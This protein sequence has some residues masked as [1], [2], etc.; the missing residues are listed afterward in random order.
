MARIVAAMA[1]THSPGLTGWFTRA[2]EAYQQ[3]ALGATAEMRRRLEAA[4]PDALVMFTNDHLLNWPINNI[5]EY[6][7]GIGE[8]HV[9]PADWFDEW[10]GM[11]K[12]RVPGHP[13]L[14][15]WIVNEGARRRL[16]FAWLRR[17]QFDDGISVPTHYL[18]PDA[19][20]RLVP[21]GMNCTVPPIPTPERAYHV[22]SVLR[23]VLHAY[24]GDD[25]IAV[26]ATG[27]LSHE[28]GGPRYFWVDEEFDRWFL[29]LLAKG[30]H[31]TLLA[32]CTLARMEGAGPGGPVEVRPRAS[33]GWTAIRPGRGLLPEAEFAKPFLQIWDL[34][35]GTH[36]RMGHGIAVP[37]EPFPGVMGTA[38]DE[39]G[40]HS[41]MPPRKNGGNMD[42]KHLVAGAT[43]YLPV[44]VDGA[45]FSVGDAHAAQGDGEVCVT[46][47]EMV[48]RVT[49]RF[50][51]QPSRVLKEPQLRTRGPLA[52]GTNHG[53][54][55]ATT[56]DAPDRCAAAQ[57]AVRYM[58]DHLVTERG[59]S[60]EEAY[61]LSSVAVDLKI[62]EIVDT[63]N[64]IVSA[65]LPESVFTQRA[66]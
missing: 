12:Y 9:G 3:L 45:L 28:P 57:Q 48:A 29:D 25:R 4:R 13:A 43:L 17:M 46:A 10:L 59:L 41:T 26:I 8:E 52:A 58:I 14:A 34:A 49:L 24:P 60:R 39:P 20:F 61:I 38:L 56:A 5:P 27:G 21:V 11:E 31:E 22:G 15:R 55:F 66:R 42:V 62:S 37:I 65:F 35:D 1:M 51:L 40:G 47:V 23:D 53:A 2:P 18:N 63:P 64:W 7:V 16:Q 32:E 30:D 33:F 44:W 19:R 6:A 36:A 54:F 50:D